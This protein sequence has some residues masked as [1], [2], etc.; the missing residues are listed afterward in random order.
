MSITE[1]SSAEVEVQDSLVRELGIKPLDR[2][3]CVWESTQNSFGGQFAR[4]FVISLLPK[5][6]PPTGGNAGL[7]SP[8]S[9]PY[10]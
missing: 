8:T 6:R 10:R 9:T 1:L 4:I 5:K 3:C 7:R 2:T